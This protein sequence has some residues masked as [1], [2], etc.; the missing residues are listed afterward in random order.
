[1]RFYT[2]DAFPSEYRNSIFI[3]RHGSWNRTKKIGGDIIVAKLNEASG[4]NLAL[5]SSD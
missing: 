4:L 5:R 1:M 2:G 3:A